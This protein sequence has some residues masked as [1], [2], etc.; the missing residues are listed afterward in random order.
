MK[1]II[2]PSQGGVAAFAC[3]SVFLEQLSRRNSPFDV[4]PLP[5]HLQRRLSGTK[6]LI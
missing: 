5:A 4:I 6:R 2:L 3:D 1:M